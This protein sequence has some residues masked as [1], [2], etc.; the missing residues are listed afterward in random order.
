M[1]L[2]TDPEKGI[3]YIKMSGNLQKKDILE[4]F[5]VAVADKRYRSGMNRLWD[6]RDADLSALD[7]ATIAE[8]AQYSSKFPDGINDAKVA[9]LVGRKLEFGLTRMFAAYASEM[10]STVKVFYSLEDAEAWLIQ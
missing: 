9:F 5:D 7:S 4:A 3:A 6:Y 1:E 10:S 2:R 8:M